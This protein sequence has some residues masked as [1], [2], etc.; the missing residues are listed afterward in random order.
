MVAVGSH[1]KILEESCSESI[2]GKEHLSKSNI[3][4]EINRKNVEELRAAI[5]TISR[6]RRIGLENDGDM[7]RVQN[8]PIR[9]L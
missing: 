6:V 1:Q 5:D 9:I 8:N 2:D 7:K 3:R 4:I